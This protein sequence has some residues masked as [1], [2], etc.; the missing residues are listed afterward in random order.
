MVFIMGGVPLSGSPCFA[1][2]DDVF[3][4]RQKGEAVRNE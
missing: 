3:L 4:G 1:R 2:I